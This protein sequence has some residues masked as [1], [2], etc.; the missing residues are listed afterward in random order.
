METLGFEER[1]E[2]QGK[3]PQKQEL[4]KKGRNEQPLPLK[5]T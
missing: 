5:L 1:Q 4:G 2:V 3:N